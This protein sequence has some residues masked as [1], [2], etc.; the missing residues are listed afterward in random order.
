MVLGNLSNL[1]LEPVRGLSLSL[2]ASYVEITLS[3]HRVILFLYKTHKSPEV[4]CRLLRESS[5]QPAP[6]HQLVH[7]GK[8]K[9]K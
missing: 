5:I 4:K 6:I 8:S 9:K 3:K 7:T 2:S 1:F